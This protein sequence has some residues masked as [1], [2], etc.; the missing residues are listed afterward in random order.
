MD[1]ERVKRALKSDIKSSMKI[2]KELQVK[3]DETKGPNA[4][5]LELFSMLRDKQNQLMGKIDAY[6]IFKESR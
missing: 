5:K 1:I 2:V 3:V 4:V 6:K